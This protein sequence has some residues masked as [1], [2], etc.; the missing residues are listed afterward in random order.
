MHIMYYNMCVVRAYILKYVYVYTYIRV[1]TYLEREGKIGKDRQ[2]Y[3]CS[4]LTEYV[5]GYF[6]FQLWPFP[7]LVLVVVEGVVQVRERLKVTVM[8]CNNYFLY[9]HSWYKY[10]TRIEKCQ[11]ETRK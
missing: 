6:L 11:L 2:K 7:Q 3:L 10:R 5:R 9:V 1:R 4:K 8:I